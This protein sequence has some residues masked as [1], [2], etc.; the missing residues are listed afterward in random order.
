MYEKK[1]PGKKRSGVDVTFYVIEGK[2]KRDIILCLN[3][4]IKRPIELQK[5]LAEANARVLNQ[6]LKELEKYG[7]IYKKI[8]P[9]VPPKVEY[10]LTDI[11]KELIPLFKVMEN[12]GN[13]YSKKQENLDSPMNP[14]ELNL[15]QIK[16]AS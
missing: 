14:N 4:G 10:Y 1:I 13:N 12:W 2:W 11:G 3:N 9:A 16:K 15:V 7:I 8:Y 5:Y 6:Q